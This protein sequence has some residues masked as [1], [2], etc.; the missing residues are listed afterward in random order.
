MNESLSESRI[1]RAF[2]SDQILFY[3]MKKVLV[4]LLKQNI[5][6]YEDIALY[7]DDYS[8]LSDVN[9]DNLKR[10]FVFFFC[11]LVSMA[12]L[13]VVDVLDFLPKVLAMSRSLFKLVFFQTEKNSRRHK[14]QRI[15]LVSNLKK[16]KIK[17][18]KMVRMSRISRHPEATV[19]VDRE[20][21]VKMIVWS[22]CN[23]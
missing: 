23:E 10:T 21:S 5:K 4:G 13:F 7:I 17:P 19:L 8:C 9:L 15:K 14:L 1:D 22:F 6:A 3:E 20:R 16:P 18:K 2:E 12:V 11:F